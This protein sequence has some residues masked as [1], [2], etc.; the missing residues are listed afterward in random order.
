MYQWPEKPFFGDGVSVLL[1][2]AGQVLFQ[3][4]MSSESNSHDLALRTGVPRG[5]PRR[6]TSSRLG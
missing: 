3:L 2:S 1:R 5:R 6:P 4:I